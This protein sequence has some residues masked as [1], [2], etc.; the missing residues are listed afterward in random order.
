MGL[1]GARV[2]VTRLA[3][4]I[5]WSMPCERM[6]EAGLYDL[7]QRFGGLFAGVWRILSGAWAWNIA[8]SSVERTMGI[9]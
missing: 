4:L 2:C 3:V 5:A 1:G 9:P 6:S 8:G 7:R